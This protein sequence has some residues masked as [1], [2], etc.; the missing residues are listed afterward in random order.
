MYISGVTY[1]MLKLIQ[2]DCNKIMKTIKSNTIDSIITDPPYGINFMGKAWDYDIPS[3]R[4]FKRMLRIAKPGAILLCFG[5]TRT[6]HRMACNIEDAGW[7]IRDCIMY[8]YGSGFPKSHNI[9]K[10]IDKAKG[11]KRKVIG[12]NTH[13]RTSKGNIWK[14]HQPHTGDGNLTEAYSKA[15]RLWDGWGTNL[16]PAFEPIIIAMKPLDGTFAHNA[17]KWGVAGLAID[18]S[19][20]T[21]KDADFKAY[22]KLIDDFGRG[23]KSQTV[24]KGNALLKSK[25]KHILKM[26]I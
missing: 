12:K 17:E 9:S 13:H 6:F 22:K 1:K 15:A 11:K 2:G 19:R 23:R 3:I 25:T 4:C 21:M 18:A 14:N 20:I 7:Q 10:S 8:M 5:G 24:Y 26:K 16:K